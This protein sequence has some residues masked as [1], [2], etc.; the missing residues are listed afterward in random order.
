MV[1]QAGGSRNVYIGQ[2]DDFEAFDE[3]NNLELCVSSASSNL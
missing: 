1:V 2:I 3:V